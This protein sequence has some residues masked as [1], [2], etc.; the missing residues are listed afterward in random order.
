MKCPNCQKEME[1]EE[2]Y[3]YQISDTELEIEEHWWCP[4]CDAMPTRF[5][6]YKAEKERI[7]K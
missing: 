6:T 1:L 4:H 5:V 2:C 7:E 3:R